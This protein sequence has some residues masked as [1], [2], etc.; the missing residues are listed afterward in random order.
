MSNKEK[1]R[2]LCSLPLETFTEVISNCDPKDV[3][4]MRQACKRAKHFCD[5]RDVQKSLLQKLDV[6]QAP[7]ITP[8]DRLDSLSADQMHSK[9]AE[10]VGSSHRWRKSGKDKRYAQE[11]SLRITPHTQLNHGDSDEWTASM[12][13]RL[14]P[15][16]R[17]ALLVNGGAYNSGRLSI[18]LGGKVLIIATKFSNLMD[19]ERGELVMVLFTPQNQIILFNWK[20]SEAVK[21]DYHRRVNTASLVENHHIVIVLKAE[22]ED[23][24]VVAISISSLDGKWTNVRH[25]SNWAQWRC[26]K[27]SFSGENNRDVIRLRLP[28]QSDKATERVFL[29][30]H[31][32]T[33]AWYPKTRTNNPGIAEIFVAA[34]EKLEDDSQYLLSYRI[35]LSG[36]AV[37]A[38]RRAVAAPDLSLVSEDRAILTQQ[39]RDPLELK[40]DITNAGRMFARYG[41]NVYCYE[42]FCKDKQ[43]VGYGQI[44]GIEDSV[45]DEENEP[46]VMSV[47]PVS[48]AVLIGSDALLRV[49]RFG[50]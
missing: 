2:D 45:F 28:N 20:K 38:A 43:P 15:G 24:K 49:A 47:E 4:H 34:Y 7:N 36:H 37:G 39:S 50:S 32:F 18:P 25:H 41:P 6:T 27:Y 22:D 23:L 48:S 12:R 14:L 9:V 8:Y 5:S 19:S 31:A 42:L 10:A 26:V 35:Q 11:A 13:P 17:Y 30:M 21:L 46:M 44:P 40:Y 1:K 3:A 16:G 33:P 29:G